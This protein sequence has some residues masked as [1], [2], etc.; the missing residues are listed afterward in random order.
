MPAGAGSTDPAGPS[1]AVARL[2]LLHD[3]DRGVLA[4]REIGVLL[5]EAMAALATMVGIDRV[6]LT[7]VHR[8]AGV[9]KVIAES[10]IGG[11]RSPVVPLDRAVTASWLAHPVAESYP[12]LG[13]RH[14][15]IPDASTL[16]ANG[17]RSLARF[18]VANDGRLWLLIMT[19]REP[20]EWTAT[21]MEILQEVA[22]QMVIAVRQATMLA[23]LTEREAQLRRILRQ[24]ANAMLVVGD[25]LR[26]EEV[27]PMAIALFELPPERL[28]RASIA[29]LLTPDDGQ[30]IEALVRAVQAEL[31]DR[32]PARK[33]AAT[34]N[35]PG[36]GTRVTAYVSRLTSGL[37]G[38]VLVELARRDGG[39][40]NA[41]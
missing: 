29:D 24:A 15:G 17:T 2:R 31:A 19:G 37:R 34:T 16:V 7:E 30:P 23:A 32:G 9:M 40:S 13:Q 22:S 18:P 5:R 35:G 6:V 21:E 20:R 33:I 8:E 10:G 28:V 12:D 39:V 3:L 1:L 36:S 27:N 25:D 11:F 38:A 41:G 4:G 26:V 14:D